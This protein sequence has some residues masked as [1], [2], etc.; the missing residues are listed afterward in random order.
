VPREHGDPLITPVWSTRLASESQL[1][2]ILE[3]HGQEHLLRFWP[4]LTPD[5]R[6]ALADD[7]RA[8]DLDEF[9][10]AWAEVSGGG[11]GHDPSTFEIPEVIDW[12]EAADGRRDRAEA[13]EAGEALIRAGK[14]G[15]MVVAGGQ[16]TRLGIDVPKG[17]FP[18]GP[19]S[20]K[21]LFEIFADGIRATNLAYGCRVPWYVMTSRAN[22]DVTVTFFEEHDWFGLDRSDV[23]FFPQG[24]IPVA[25]TGGK[26]L[27]E[28]R[29]RVAMSPNGHGGSVTALAGSGMLADMANR[30]VEHLSY[31]QVDNPLVRP[32]DPEFA[33]IHAMRR[34]QVS[35][36]T[37]GK[38]S[39]EEKVGLFVSIGGRVHVVEY[40]DFPVEMMREQTASGARK[41]DLANIAVHLFDRSFLE[42][43]TAVGSETS[44]PWHRAVKK[45]S[46]VDLG[47]GSLVEP[48]EPN[49]VKLEMFVF[50]TVPLAERTALL[51]VA[52]RERFSPVKNLEGVDSVDTAKQDMTARAA[53]WLEACGVAVPRG[54]DGAP[55]CAIEITAN[56][57][58]DADMLRERESGSHRTVQPG[59]SL[60]LDG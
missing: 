28:S 38:A 24:M 34:A 53:S 1:R 16:A 46:H 4:D 18:I 59:E 54:V 26:I 30:G 27:L 8:L 58:L 25:D 29:H 39:D 43:V 55:E 41:F 51:R 13:I 60:L 17:A 31:F 33:G 12:G 49:A 19:V 57:A 20:G 6:S 37:M 50:D 48:V 23:L 5:E 11:G 45:V 32:I 56:H 40:S 7:I 21:S 14:M 36:L 9:D 42:K 2:E 47:D 35:S 44:L 22:H 3:P 15:A 52:R 10:R